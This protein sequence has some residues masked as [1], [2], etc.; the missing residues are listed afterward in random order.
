M[1]LSR[2]TRWGLNTIRGLSWNEMT[3]WLE[4]AIRFEIRQGAT[5]HV[6]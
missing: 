1:A 5:W 4:E 6:Q 3:E 2:L